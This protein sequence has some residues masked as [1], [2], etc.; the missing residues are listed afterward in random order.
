MR[1][2]VVT[3]SFLPRVN[4]VTNSVLRLLEH[5]EA[6]GHAALVLAPDP[7]ERGTYAAARVV[8]LPSLAFAGRTPVSMSLAGTRRLHDELAAF[9]PD[10]LHLASP[11]MTGPPALRAAERLGVPVGAS[12]QTDVAGFARESGLAALEPTI[13]RRLRR[14]HDAADITLVPSRATR[15]MLE[16]RGF[17]RLHL[18]PRGV[19]SDRFAPWHRDSEVRARLGRGR[20]VLVG[21]VGRLGPEKELELLAPLQSLPG[22]RLVVIGDGPSRPML[23]NAMPEA[24]FTGQLGGTDLSAAIASLDVMVHPGRYET[25]CQA[26]QEALASGVPV[27]AAAAGGPLDLVQPSRTGWLFRPGD[28][29]DLRTWVADLV[30]DDYKRRAMGTMARISVRQRSWAAVNG[31]LVARYAE[32]ARITRHQV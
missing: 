8:G 19:D 2:A 17:E 9:A 26:V 14:I 10:V 28:A 22:V 24:T 27:V 3:E 11:F 4:G 29:E 16:E 31:R 5:L 7:V 32:L 13:W 6:E 25:F 20:P 15:T 30:G 18:W 23:E 21:Y 1:V 12:F